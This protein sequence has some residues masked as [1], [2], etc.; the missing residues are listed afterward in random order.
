MGR[1]RSHRGAFLSS[2]AGIAISVFISLAIIIAVGIV[3]D[4]E[5]SYDRTVLRVSSAESIGDSLSP[6][7]WYE[8]LDDAEKQAYAVMVESMSSGKIYDLEDHTV[9]D[10]LPGELTSDGSAF[11]EDD[12]QVLLSIWHKAI[13]DSPVLSVYSTAGNECFILAY[14]LHFAMD[15]PSTREETSEQIVAEMD[16][17]RDTVT[18]FSDEILSVSDGNVASYIYEAF[19]MMCESTTYSKAS[20]SIHYND[21]YGALEEGTAQCFGVSCAFK[22]IL[23]EVGIPNFIATGK[24]SE[25]LHAWNVVRMDGKWLVCDITVGMSVYESVSDRLGNIDA[26]TAF[27]S[28][29][30]DTIAC[31]IDQDSYATRGVEIDADSLEI[32]RLFADG[33]SPLGEPEEQRTEQKNTQSLVMDKSVFIEERL[34]Q[35]FIEEPIGDAVNSMVSSTE[36]GWSDI[37]SSFVEL[38]SAVA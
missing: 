30:N 25:G 37:A 3:A 29:S 15:T 33:E 34:S 22:A 5:N 35:I 21:I 8:T 10:E 26:D 9:W 24:S 13:S 36:R 1:N 28:L 23:D 7:S 16:E 14:G 38:F 18:R 2:A 12:M 6:V 19:V 17:M 20:T 11:D 32:E 4:I 27:R 31:L